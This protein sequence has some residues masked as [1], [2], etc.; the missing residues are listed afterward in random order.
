MPK[1]N[2][3]MNLSIKYQSQGEMDKNK[4]RIQSIIDRNPFNSEKR[5]NDARNQASKIKTEEKAFNR[6]V[7]AKDMGYEDIF[8]VFFKR[9]YELGSV[10]TKDYR[11]YKLEKLG[12]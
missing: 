11:L 3:T 7:I 2:I 10:S 9:A 4:K 12:L 8:E 1:I 6:A 5:S